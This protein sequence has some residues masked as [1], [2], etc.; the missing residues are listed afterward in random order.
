MIQ[1]LKHRQKNTYF[2]I[3][4]DKQIF[5]S[6]LLNL[7]YSSQK[8]FIISPYFMGVVETSLVDDLDVYV[9]GFVSYEPFYDF[10][11]FMMDDPSAIVRGL[12]FFV[13]EIAQR[14][15]EFLQFLQAQVAGHF[16]PL[17]RATSCYFLN[18]IIKEG[19]I[20]CGHLD[21]TF[22]RL[23]SD[24]ISKVQN[25]HY[26]GNFS[27]DMLDWRVIDASSLDNSALL[28]LPNQIN[29]GLSD[30]GNIISEKNSL[31]FSRIRKY[32]SNGDNTIILACKTKGSVV[33][34]LENKFDVIRVQESEDSIGIIAHNV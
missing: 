1:Q 23:T 21:P 18:K 31:S 15:V 22:A 30:S 7:V 6:D 16:D 20:T 8:R 28:L 11:R 32:L 13:K 25:F 33:S 27:V 17:Y 19:T 5:Y 12:D 2:D 14:N 26:N 3:L 34:Y 9:K 29:R 24:V 4:D 10:W